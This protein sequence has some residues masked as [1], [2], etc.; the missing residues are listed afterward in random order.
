[1]RKFRPTCLVRLY[2]PSLSLVK[3]R[4]KA[5]RTKDANKPTHMKTELES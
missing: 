3:T 5:H 2:F 1:M 4:I